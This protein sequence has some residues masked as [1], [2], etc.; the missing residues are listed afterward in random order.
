MKEF[1]KMTEREAM[2]AVN[3]STE[4]ITEEAVAANREKYGPNE[5]AEGKKKSIART[6]RWARPVPRL[7]AKLPDRL[8]QKL[9]FPKPERFR[10][11]PE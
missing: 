10:K 5:I 4:P 2:I 11:M 8:L 7:S 3:G 1:Y 6:F 9:C